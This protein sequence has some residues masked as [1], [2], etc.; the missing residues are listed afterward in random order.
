MEIDD[1]EC[2]S[3][4]DEKQKDAKPTRHSAIL[5]LDFE[6]E[7]VAQT[8]CRVV[9]VDK[10]PS[11]SNAIRSFNVEGPRL[12]IEIKSVDR[13]SLQKSIANV[14]EMCDLAKS[15][16]DLTKNKKW[17][18]LKGPVQKKLKL[19]SSNSTH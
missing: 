15:T 18:D 10:E 6:S 3:S 7:E 2:S 1:G 5:N 19:N 12:L 16:V 14:M 9:S 11:R 8:V 13:K 17:L 4:D